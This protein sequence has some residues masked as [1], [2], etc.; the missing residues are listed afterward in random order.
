M[1]RK[2]MSKRKQQRTLSK[3]GIVII[4][5][6]DR[7]IVPFVHKYDSVEFLC[8]ND[9]KFEVMFTLDGSGIMIREHSVISH[10]MVVLPESGNVIKV[11]GRRRYDTD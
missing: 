7:Q 5:V 3:V 10:E 2:I 1:K 6:D 11:K 9:A 4:D 8:N